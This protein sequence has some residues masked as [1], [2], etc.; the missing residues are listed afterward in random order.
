[1][2]VKRLVREAYHS[3]P[4][5]A[6]NSKFLTVC[7]NFEYKYLFTDS[8]PDSFIQSK[9]MKQIVLPSPSG[10]VARNNHNTALPT[11]FQI[12]PT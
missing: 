8:R 12:N 5:S 9:E 6:G 2:G 4:S 7:L 1:M 3:P 10:T 11:S